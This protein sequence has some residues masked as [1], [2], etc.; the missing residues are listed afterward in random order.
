MRAGRSIRSTWKLPPGD[1]LTRRILSPQHLTTLGLR[2][3]ELY[4]PDVYHTQWG[5]ENNLD[6]YFC[7]AHHLATILL[8]DS[9][10]RKTPT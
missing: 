3:G 6:V 5:I 10:R 9:E 8:T 2:D 4:L 1:P 7:S